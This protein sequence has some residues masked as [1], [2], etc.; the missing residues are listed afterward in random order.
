MGDGGMTHGGNGHLDED[1]LEQY[2]MGNLPESE[3]DAFEEHLLVCEQCRLRL[4]EIDEY[5]ASM[6]GA[7]A[8]F[9]SGQRPAQV[10]PQ[11]R[12]WG[13][14]RLISVGA[15]V[16]AL[17]V[18]IGW[19]SGSSDMAGPPFAI[20]L[21]AT[22]GA[23]STAWAPADTSLL[24][25]LDLA[26]LPDFPTYRMQMVDAAGAAVWQGTA[27]AHDSKVESKIPQTKAGTYFIRVYSP[28]GELLREFGLKTRER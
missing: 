20:S 12:P 4:E 14:L 13:W 11:R 5:T 2:S 18:V 27:A 7:A 25:R 3:S 10:E 24:V 16:A 6:R 26:G 22:R 28:A 17:V 9:R 21:E 1:E 8:E 23:A 19:W 15:A